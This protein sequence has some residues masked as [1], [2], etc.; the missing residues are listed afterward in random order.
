MGKVIFEF[1]DDK[2]SREIKNIINYSTCLK[3]TR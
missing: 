3:N 1:N 2:D